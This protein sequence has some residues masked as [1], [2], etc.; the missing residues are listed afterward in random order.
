MPKSL[1]PF[2]WIKAEMEVPEEV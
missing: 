2:I 1:K